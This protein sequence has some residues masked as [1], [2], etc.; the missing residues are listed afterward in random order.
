MGKGNPHALREVRILLRT[1]ATTRIWDNIAPRFTPLKNHCVRWTNAFQEPLFGLSK[2]KLGTYF[3]FKQVT[4]D[5]PIGGDQEHSI[6]LIWNRETMEGWGVDN[7]SFGGSDRFFNPWLVVTD[8]KWP[9]KARDDLMEAI[10]RLN[11]VEPKSR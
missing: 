1:A 2:E 9:Q 6:V 10:K 5:V 4:L 7:G 11:I 8:S 3:N